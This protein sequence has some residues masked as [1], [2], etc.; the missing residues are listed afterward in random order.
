M[1]DTTTLRSAEG[2]TRCEYA[3]LCEIMGRSTLAPEVFNRAAPDSANMETLL[4]YGTDVV[5]L[6]E[7][8]RMAGEAAWPR[9]ADFGPQGT[10]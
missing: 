2:L 7:A 5:P 4:R 10:T 1:S 8:R 3:P 9:P 6:D